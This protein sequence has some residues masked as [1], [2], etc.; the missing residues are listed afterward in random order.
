MITETVIGLVLGL[1]LIAGIVLLEPRI[2]EA[3]S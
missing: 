3:V 1:L 2:R